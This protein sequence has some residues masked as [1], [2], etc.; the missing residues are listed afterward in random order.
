MFIYIL[1]VRVCRFLTA[2]YRIKAQNAMK[3]RSWFFKCFFTT[4]RSPSI[5][6]L[7][8][9]SLPYVQ[10]D[11]GPYQVEDGK[12]NIFIIVLPVKEVVGNADQGHWHQGKCEVL[13]K[14]KVECQTFTK[15]MPDIIY[16]IKHTK[17]QIT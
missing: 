10:E 12:Q 2:C 1:A 8:T 14:T 11:S 6:Q 4:Q 9:T 13:Q 17:E 5:S 3:S 15:V 7:C 16:I